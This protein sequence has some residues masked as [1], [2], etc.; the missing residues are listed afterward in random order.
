LFSFFP[1]LVGKKTVV[2]VQ[3]RD[4]QRKKWGRFASLTL[5]LGELASAR[6]P[7]RTMV[8][9]RALQQHYQEVYGVTTEYVPNGSMIR[10]RVASSHMWEW[11]LEPDKYIL[12][13]GRFSPEKNCHLLIEAYEKLDTP[14]K[15]VLAGGSSYANSY[16]DDLRKHQSE[17]VLFL[18]WVHG[19]TLDELLTNAALFVLPSD[20]EGLSLALLDAMGAAVCVLTS[21]IPENREVIEGT[22]FTFQRG[23]AADLSRM[24]HTLL[25]DAPA[26]SAAGR[27]A[28]ARVRE[29]YLW[30]QIAAEIQHSYLELTDR[31]DA[32]E[33]YSPIE[34]PARR[35]SRLVG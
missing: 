7:N 34:V 22:G 10:K 31:A 21:D 33:V 4:W 30:P 32:F 20:L 35:T 25:S 12:F 14:V 26:R 2:T 17:H 3:G 16:V 11:G 9:S 13:M 28:Q 15:L 5:R 6:L 19:A 18:D 27:N 1:R 24:L 8:V 29:R 23:D